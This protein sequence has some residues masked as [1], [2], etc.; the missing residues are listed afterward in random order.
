MYSHPGA[1]MGMGPAS[2]QSA[3]GYGAGYGG[4]AMPTPGPGYPYTAPGLGQAPQLRF[5]GHGPTSSQAAAGGLPP[6]WAHT[7]PAEGAPT[8]AHGVGHGTGQAGPQWHGAPL[9][10]SVSATGHGVPAAAGRPGGGGAYPTW[11]GF[12]QASP[13]HDPH[14]LPLDPKGSSMGP[15]GVPQAAPS[16]TGTRPPPAQPSGSAHATAATPRALS[17]KGVKRE[18]PTQAWGEAGP[19]GGPGPV[20]GRGAS[21]PTQGGPAST[22][23]VTVAGSGHGLPVPFH[24]LGAGQ[25]SAKRLRPDGTPAPVPKAIVG[26]GTRVQS[27]ALPVPV[28]AHTP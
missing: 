19:Q 26:A 5:E 14:H 4:P 20:E 8:W 18:A 11:P 15:L 2:A 3:P 28:R 24:D 10:V 16:S 21:G 12:P 27:L 1:P 22:P 6:H 25:S 13:S 9:T 17:R 23:A 7:R